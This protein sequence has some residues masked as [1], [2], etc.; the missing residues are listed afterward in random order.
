MTREM[1]VSKHESL[2]RIIEMARGNKSLK[3]EIR[4]T[5]INDGSGYG[6]LLLRCS[7][8]VWRVYYHRPCGPLMYSE[9]RE[10]FG[11]IHPGS[12]A[13]DAFANLV[14]GMFPLPEEQC[15]QGLDDIAPHPLR[16]TW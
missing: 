9:F 7:T 3:W 1:R 6:V 2:W 15:T 14:Q 8:Y 10:N 5:H 11:G 13:R 16:G 4:D 12:L